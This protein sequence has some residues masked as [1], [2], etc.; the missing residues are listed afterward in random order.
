MD[1]TENVMESDSV[2]FQD[3]TT[4]LIPPIL[5]KSLDLRICRYMISDSF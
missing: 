1:I 4:V 2:F 3:L 5:Q